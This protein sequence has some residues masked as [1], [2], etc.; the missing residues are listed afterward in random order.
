MQLTLVGVL[1]VISATAVA[2]V[3]IAMSNARGLAGLKGR[4]RCAACGRRR[5]KRRCPC[6]QR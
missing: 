5:T 6:T 3:M 1:P 2:W 4:A